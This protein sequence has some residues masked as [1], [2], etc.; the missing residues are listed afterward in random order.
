MIAIKSLQ[1]IL[2]IKMAASTDRGVVMPVTIKSQSRRLISVVAHDHAFEVSIPSARQHIS[3]S[4]QIFHTD[5]FISYFHLLAYL[6]I[7][8]YMHQ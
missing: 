7:F 6:F 2:N 1:K 5:S 8:S 3:T 4:V